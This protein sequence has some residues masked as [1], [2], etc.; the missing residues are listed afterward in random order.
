MSAYNSDQEFFSSEMF[1]VGIFS[2]IP[3]E[4]D[5]TVDQ[6]LYYTINVNGDS[7]INVGSSYTYIDSSSIVN[8]GDGSYLV[9]S[10]NLQSTQLQSTTSQDIH[11]DYPS[12]LRFGI[13]KEFEE[14]GI[15]AIDLVTGF[16]DSFGNSSKFRL[17]IG[18]ETIRVHKNF[19]IRIGF[20]TGGRQP[21]SYS[22][23]IGYKAGPLNIDF[24]RK[25]YYGIKK[26]EPVA[27][28]TYV[29]FWI[30]R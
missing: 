16:D 13:S 15:L 3:L 21:S 20:S 17:S 27:N 8:L 25:Y 6:I 18:T 11:L 22:L 23:G 24:S 2:D 30:Q 9:P 10:E 7:I 19:P 12:F 1:K 26:V 28:S 4:E 5:Y 14:Y 29:V